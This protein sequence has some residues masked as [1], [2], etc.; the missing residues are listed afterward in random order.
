MKRYV[1]LQT[2]SRE[3]HGAL[4]LAKKLKNFQSLNVKQQSDLAEYLDQNREEYFNHFAQEESV[5]LPMLEANTAIAARLMDDHKMLRS[6]FN[7]L[8]SET[9]LSFGE[10]LSQHIRFEEKELFQ[11]LQL[12]YSD[13]YIAKRFELLSH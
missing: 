11:W 6:Y 7:G 10:L 1:S 9:F 5:L 12:T 8:N 3:H 4:V 13:D 2:L